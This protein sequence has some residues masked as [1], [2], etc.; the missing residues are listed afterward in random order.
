MRDGGQA[1]T[2]HALIHRKALLI[3]QFIEAYKQ[4][5]KRASFPHKAVGTMIRLL[6]PGSTLSGRGAF[7]TVHKVSSRERDLVL[8]TGN[9]RSMYSDH[10][11]Y[12][13]V[14]STLRNR[15]FAKVYWRTRYCLLQKYGTSGR[16]PPER[17]L[18]LKEVGRRFR[19]TD[20][21]EA[22]IRKVEGAFKIV[23]ANLSTRERPRESK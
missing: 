16:V 8:K 17:L 12:R 10:R 4:G 23:D 6:F 13:R 22:N 11:A 2:R 15:Y 5:R 19:L 21:R 14:P 9:R 7:K 3:D 20:I 1:T 18:R